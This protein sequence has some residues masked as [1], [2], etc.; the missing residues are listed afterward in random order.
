MPTSE[1]LRPGTEPSSEQ[2]AAQLA[3]RDLINQFAY[4]VDNG[5]ASQVVDLFT[6]DAE[7]GSPERTST[8]RDELVALMAVREA[9]T[10]RRTRHQVTNIVFRRTGPDTAQ[11]NSL[12]C[13]YVLGG[14]TE[15][16]AR[17]ITVFEDEFARDAHGRWRFSRR[18]AQPLA[19]GR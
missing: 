13:L 1:E 17:A 19:G 15:L 16:T 6:E 7:L 12:L 9:A 18:R 4:L 5:M 11:A 10:D 8:G 14:P 3:C 2:L